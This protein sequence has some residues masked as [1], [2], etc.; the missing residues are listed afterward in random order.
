MSYGLSYETWKAVAGRAVNESKA[1][2]GLGG[3]YVIARPV[4]RIVG[5]TGYLR[6][7]IA[8]AGLTHLKRFTRGCDSR[9]FAFC[10]MLALGFE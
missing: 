8:S 1:A 10:S 5:H 7:S 3:G 6:S 4:Q 2:T 9:N